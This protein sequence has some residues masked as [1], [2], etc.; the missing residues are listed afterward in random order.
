MT[1]RAASNSG[2]KISTSHTYFPNLQEHKHSLVE[3]LGSEALIH[4]TLNGEPFIIKA[5]TRN[6]ARDFS[7]LDR[8]TVAPDMLRVFDRATGQAITAQNKAVAA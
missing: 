4:A 2:I 6:G 5:D 3:T 7:G 8:F 1:Q